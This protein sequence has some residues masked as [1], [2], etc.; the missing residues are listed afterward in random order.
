LFIRLVSSFY[1]YY[2]CHRVWLG[3]F[4]FQSNPDANAHAGDDS[5]A[6][7]YTCCNSHAVAQSNTN[8]SA[9]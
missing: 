3:Q 1:D 6:H 9:F 2:P 8:A 5:I 4:W 7:A